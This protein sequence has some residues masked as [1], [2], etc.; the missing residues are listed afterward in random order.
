M[1]AHFFSRLHPKHAN[2]PSLFRG[3][4]A[5]GS[6]QN[7]LKNKPP[8]PML[9]SP[10]KSSPGNQKRAQN[11]Q[12]STPRGRPA[13]ISDA[14]ASAS[15]VTRSTTDFMIFKFWGFTECLQIH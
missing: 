6:P 9:Q 5:S 1:Q 10:Q 12:K 14:E 13:N 4:S 7:S 8:E 11:P 15:L 2:L 3:A